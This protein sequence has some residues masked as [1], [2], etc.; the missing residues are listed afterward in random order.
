MKLGSYARLSNWRRW[1]VASRRTR[2]LWRQSDESL[3]RLASVVEQ[4]GTLAGAGI[5]PGQEEAMQ[6]LEA[7]YTMH[8]E[9]VVHDRALAEEPVAASA[10][11]W[12]DNVELF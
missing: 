5:G 6:K 10:G 8:V 1:S 7:R 11:E 4:A 12:G 3:Q 2:C 9:R